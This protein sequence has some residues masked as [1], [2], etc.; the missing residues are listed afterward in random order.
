[1]R[2]GEGNTRGGNLFGGKSF[3]KTLLR[4]GKLTWGGNG[5]KGDQQGV[6]RKN[7]EDNEKPVMRQ[8]IPAWIEEK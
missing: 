3:R 2:M 4:Q 7:G 6:V 5:E 8:V 1:M